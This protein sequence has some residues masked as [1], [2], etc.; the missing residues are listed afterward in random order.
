MSSVGYVI[1]SQHKCYP[2]DVVEVPQ[3]S[4]AGGVQMVVLPRNKCVVV[5]GAGVVGGP[6]Q[7]QVCECPQWGVYI[8]ANQG[9]TERR[10]VYL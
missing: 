8:G 3:V 10:A 6:P 7:D 1:P 2:G 5:R 4:G 9:L